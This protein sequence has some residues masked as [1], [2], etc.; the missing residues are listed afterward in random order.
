[1]FLIM[2]YGCQTW[3][4]NKQLANKLTTAQRATE[5]KMLD[6]QLQD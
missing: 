2:A 1:M 5:R 6:L 4:L 3:S